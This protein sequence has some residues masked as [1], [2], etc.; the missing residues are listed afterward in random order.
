MEKLN[1]LF[2]NNGFFPVLTVSV[3]YYERLVPEEERHESAVKRSRE[4]LASELQ[5]W[6]GY[7]QKV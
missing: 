6:E 4:A 5:L 7:M 3:I 2:S 1:C